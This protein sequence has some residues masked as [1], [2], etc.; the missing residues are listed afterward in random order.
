MNKEEVKKEIAI[1]EGKLV[2]LKKALAELEGKKP[3]VKSIGVDYSICASLYELNGTIVSINTESNPVRGEVNVWTGNQNLVVD[4]AIPQSAY[5]EYSH[6]YSE[7]KKVSCLFPK[8]SKNPG[9][10]SIRPI[11]QTLKLVY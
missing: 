8:E 1:I 2:E 9:V 7:G 4:F 11:I 6:K 10:I 5:I 3:Q